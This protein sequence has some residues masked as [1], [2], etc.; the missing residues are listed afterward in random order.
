[1]GEGFEK[2]RV[3]AIHDLSGAGKCSLTVVLPVLSALGCAVSVLPTAL[4]STH[5]G[6]FRDPVCR[7]LTGDMLPWA[8]HW[9]REGACFDAV[10]SGFL[11]SAAQIEIVREIFGMFR[12]VNPAV[13]I[14]VDP[15]MGD[16]GRL[17]KIC[18]PT[19]IESLRRLCCAADYITPNVTEAAV[20]LDRPADSAPHS[21]DEAAGW[22]RALCARY[23]TCTVLTGLGDGQ[24]IYTLCGQGDTVQAVQNPRIGAYYPGTG[25][26]FAAVLLG[27]LMQGADM[28]EAAQR[29]A[30][31]V[32]ACIRETAR[33]GTD[34]K[35]GVALETQLWRLYD[36]QDLTG[37]RTV[38]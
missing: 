1:M 25:D 28:A 36:G 11:G 34:P 35:W 3:L 21:A 37:N 22:V 13:R 32:C 14:V 2:K 23:E 29:A 24:T 10:Y 8:E 16:G 9:R 30:D 19:L 4:L 38:L 33:M 26:L 7:D 5:T 12:E 31:F 27:G 6:G 18:T 17:Y 15:V 20:L